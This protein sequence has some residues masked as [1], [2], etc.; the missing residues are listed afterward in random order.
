MPDA[1]APDLLQQVRSECEA[2]D[3]AIV[4][5]SGTFNMIHPD[6]AQRAD[7]LRRLE[8][9]APATRA[10][11]CQFISLCSGTRDAQDMWRAHPDNDTPEAWKDLQTTLQQAIQIAGRHDILLGVEPETG[12]VVSSARKARYL[13]DEMKSPRLKI[14][15]DPANLFHGGRTERMR[16]T[17]DEAFQLLAPDIHLAH[18]KELAADGSMGGAA[19]GEGLVDWNF[20]L[21]CLQRMH[22]AG[23]LVLHGLPETSVARAVA[24]LRPRNAAI[25]SARSSTPPPTGGPDVRAP[26]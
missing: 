6:A 15:I 17:I 5:V 24:F 14:I 21:Q 20:Y 1:L 8:V 12:N 22:F 16:E 26:E 19:P 13:L 7:G 4:G 9:L 10:L 23:P 18:A 3:I 25:L 2:R 11:G